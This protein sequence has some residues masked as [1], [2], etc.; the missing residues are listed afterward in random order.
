MLFKK[1]IRTIG[2]YK[3]QFISMIVMIA[4]GIGIF[5]GFNTEWYTIEKNTK[6]FFS[7]CKLSDYKIADVASSG[8]S[9]EDVE[10]IKAIDGV[11]AATLYFSVNAEVEEKEGT[12]VALDV[13]K[14]RGVSEFVVIKGEKYD[15]S[16]TDGIWLSETYANKNGVK[17]GDELT[18]SYGDTKIKGVVK[19]FIKAAE[20]MVCVRDASQ[21]MPDY[22]TYGYAYV[23][24]ALYEGKSS[25]ALYKYIYVRS[26]IGSD[27]FKEKV[28]AVFGKTML[29]TTKNENVSYSQSK[30]EIEEG[31]T[32]GSILP[33]VFLI[34]AVLTMVTT[35]HRLTVK[36]KGQIGILKALGFKNKKILAHYTSY[37]FFIG[38]VGISIGIGLG[39]LIAYIIMNPKGTMSTYFDMPSWTL[40]A[41]WFCWLVLALLLAALTL[42]GFFSVRKMLKGTAAETLQPYSPKKVK[43]LAIEKTKLWNKFSFGTKWNMRDVMRHKSRTLMSLIGIIGCTVIIVASFGMRNTMDKYLN[44]YYTGAMNYSTK[45]FLTDDLATLSLDERAKFADKFEGDA[46]ASIP[47]QLKEKDGSEKTVSLDIY[48]IAHNKVRFPSDGGGYINLGDQGAYLCERIADALG[49]KVG[50]AFKVKPYGS[51]D[52]YTIKVAAINRSVSESIV[53]TAGYAATFGIPVKYDAIYTGK[54]KTEINN[55]IATDSS[56]AN[57]IKTAQSKQDIIKSFDS[58]LEIMNNMIILLIV[59]GV[60]LGVV[61]LYNLGVMSYTERYR[62][63]ATLKVVGYKDKKI[64]GLLISQNMWITL[65]GV[66]IG[67]PCGVGLLAGLMKALASEYELKISVSALSYVVSIAITFGVSLLVSLAVARKNKKIDMVEALK[68]VE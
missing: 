9:E 68:G 56:I 46:S 40:Y 21:L 5:V 2:Q 19:A 58:F 12:Q 65:V 43:K 32:M 60:V 28:N 51:S 8:F 24:P 31:Q 41:P 18:F 11:D 10:K 42:I 1:L 3:A 47:V 50:G 59:A 39:Y 67:I 13:A 38:V 25:S 48:R 17:L 27:S 33:V 49:V 30:G 57:K 54:T 37:A 52:E 23:S 6:S 45:I 53:V 63:M 26:N 61:V 64:G 34:I 22:T 20:H 35:M 4:I 7:D 29:V 16:S 55:L 66:I 44:T 62:E 15:P 14:T 36:E